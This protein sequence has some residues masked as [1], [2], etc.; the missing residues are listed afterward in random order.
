MLEK[1]HG[2]DGGK[3]QKELADILEMVDVFIGETE[4]RNCFQRAHAKAHENLQS[5]NQTWNE[6]TVE[7][8]FLYQRVLKNTL[9]EAI[10]EHGTKLLKNIQVIEEFGKIGTGE[11]APAASATEPRAS[12][13]QRKETGEADP[14]TAPR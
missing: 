5:R 1:Y 7:W 8:A 11:S 12:P 3:K 9:L 6:T 2:S 13:E 14:I 4:R 10:M